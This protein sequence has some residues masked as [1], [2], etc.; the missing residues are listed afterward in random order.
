M[1]ETI[2][3]DVAPLDKKRGYPI[4]DRNP[5]VPHPNAIASKRK[6]FKVANG[7][8]VMI[9]GRDSGEVLGDGHAAFFEMK[10]VDETQFIKLYLAGIKQTA[11]L[12]A[13]GLKIF[14]LMYHQMRETPQSDKI[15]LNLYHVKKHGLNMTERTYQRGMREM[16]DHQF[17][18]RSTS[19][20]VYFVNIKFVFNG[21]RITL[22]KSYY[23]KGTDG[24]QLGLDL[25]PPSPALPPPDTAD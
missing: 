7:N 23:L 18:F 5:S 2:E 21:N 15:E 14:E 3:S 11:K 9:V 24:A 1:S 19:A 12:T 17:L 20:D 25:P 4:Y 13:A 8:R 10:E 22:A 16:L 6:P